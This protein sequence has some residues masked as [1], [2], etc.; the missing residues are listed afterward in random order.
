MTCVIWIQLLGHQTYG[1]LVSYQELKETIFLLKNI[2]QTSS[3]IIPMHETIKYH[4]VGFVKDK[5][6]QPYFRKRRISQ[7]KKLS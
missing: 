6:T 1:T 5:C 2:R 3:L 7:E 4:Y